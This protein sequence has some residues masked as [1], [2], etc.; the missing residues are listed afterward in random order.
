MSHFD[1]NQ[2]EQE[3]GV[4]KEEIKEVIRSIEEHG[5]EAAVARIGTRPLQRAVVLLLSQIFYDEFH[6][7]QPQV[8]RYDIT[9]D[10]FEKVKWVYRYWFNQLEVAEKKRRP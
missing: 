6:Y 1:V 2:L 8:G 7:P 9:G 4:D 10:T 3:L 5:W